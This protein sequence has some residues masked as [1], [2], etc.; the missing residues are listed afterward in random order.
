MYKNSFGYYLFFS[1]TD[2]FMNKYFLGTY[3]PYGYYTVFDKLID[4]PDYFTYILKG[5]QSASRLIETV[6]EGTSPSEVY[7]CSAQPD[8]LDAA[9]FGESR[10]IVA[11]SIKPHIFEP[12]VPGACQQIVNI[13]EMWDVISLKNRRAELEELHISHKSC[14]DG[15]ARSLTALGSI[16]ADSLKI[17][18]AALMTD[19]LNSF[20][21]RFIKKNIPK[22]RENAKK[23]G[24]SYRQICAVTADGFS[25][26]IPTDAKEV[27]IIS[28]DFSAGTDYLL[29][30]LTKIAADRGY[31]CV[32]TRS[33]LHNIEPGEVL[34]A[35]YIPEL[36]TV[37]INSTEQNPVFAEKRKIINFKRFYDKAAAAKNKGRLR[38]DAAAARSLSNDIYLSMK[39]ARAVLTQIEKIY[40]TAA[41]HSKIKNVTEKI[42]SDVIC[43][44]GMA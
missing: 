44:D 37:F 12:T 35:L 26:F 8:C 38:F 36:K 27:F 2:F 24:I 20:I 18:K 25:V 15:A 4:Q 39:A 23:G 16:T 28:D 43:S 11:D 21:T 41:E 42:K 14:M 1:G 6:T 3:T 5:D 40:E 32:L 7:Y 30:E 22:N 13:G 31:D 33:P 17:G 29:R 9:V 10:I 19:K 34:F